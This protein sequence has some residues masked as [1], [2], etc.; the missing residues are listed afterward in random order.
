MQFTAK[1]LLTTKGLTK[2]GHKR[3]AARLKKFHLQPNTC[4]YGIT[5]KFDTGGY[6]WRL[7]QLV[8]KAEPAHVRPFILTG[9]TSVFYIE[10]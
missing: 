8:K 7:A 2:K 5:E 4:L 10:N 6:L 9:K 3:L 1:D